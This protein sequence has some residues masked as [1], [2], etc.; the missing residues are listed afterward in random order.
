MVRFIIRRVTRDM[1]HVSNQLSTRD[2]ECQELEAIL[3]QGGRGG[4]PDGD[5]FEYCE[6]VGAEV[7]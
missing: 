2:I 5:D 4:G 6:L 7:R 1:G 3:R